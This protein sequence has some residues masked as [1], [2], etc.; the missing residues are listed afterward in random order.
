MLADHA[1]QLLVTCHLSDLFFICY[2]SP[3]RNRQSG[4]LSLSLAFMQ[5]VIVDKQKIV[6]I[7]PQISVFY[8]SAL[9]YVVYPYTPSISIRGH[10]VRVKCP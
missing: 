9:S 10:Y 7:I 2:W 5:T 4:T 6:T 1:G 8:L 3:M